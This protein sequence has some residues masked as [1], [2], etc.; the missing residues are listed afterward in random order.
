MI[1]HIGNL[2]AVGLLIAGV[3]GVVGQGLFA[4]VAVLVTAL[5]ALLG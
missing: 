2:W 5:V 4:W 1:G 3:L